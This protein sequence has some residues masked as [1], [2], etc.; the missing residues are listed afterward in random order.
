MGYILFN[1]NNFF[2]FYSI[3]PKQVIELLF[4]TRDIQRLA[5]R[6]MFHHCITNHKRLDINQINGVLIQQNTMHKSNYNL[7]ELLFDNREI[8][9]IS[10][11]EAGQKIVHISQF[12]FI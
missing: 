2:T 7:K 5:N 3:C 6:L 12:H 11:K 9:K 10:Y 1:N 4:Q 8:F